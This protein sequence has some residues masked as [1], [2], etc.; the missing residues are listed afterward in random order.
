[1]LKHPKL[2]LQRIERFLDSELR[3]RVYQDAAPL[4]VAVCQCAEPIAHAEALR[5]TYRPVAPGFRWG[6]VWSTAWFR[7]RGRM[8]DFFA[9][10][11]VVARINTSS[12]A[13]VWEGDSPSQGLD[14]NRSEYFLSRSAVA[15]EPVELFVEA[16]GNHLFGISAMGRTDGLAGAAEPFELKEACLARFDRRHWDLYHDF[17]VLLGVLKA[18]PE[19]EPRR[20]QLLY[21]L[22]ECANCYVM[23]C[24]PEAAREALAPALALPASASSH[25]VSAL[26]HSHID[27][28]W[29]WPLRETVRKC[30]RTFATALRTMERY[31]E[32]RF[33]QSQ[34]QLYAFTKEHFPKLYERI[35]RAVADGRWEPVGAM[36]VE[37][38]CNIPSGE[39][40][41]RQIL[42]GKRFFMEEFGVESDIAWLPDA[43]GYS[44][45]LP[46][47]LKKARVDYFVTQKL[48]WSQF[49]RFPHHAFWWEGID[50][51]RILSHFLP[52]DTYNG[53]FTPEQLRHGERAFRE[54]D[55]AASWLYLFGY[56]DGGGGPTPE[57]LETAQRVKS[58]DGL[59]RV[60][61]EPARDFFRRAAAEAK[62]LPLWVGEL[63]LE[64][65]R[66]T[67]TTQ[68]H[69]KLM[70]RR[71]ELLLRD[72][73]F[74][75]SIRP[76]GLKSYPAA[77]L[78]RCWKLVLLNQF[79]DVLPGSSIGRVYADSRQQYAE[80][81]ETGE[82]LVARSLGELT[83]R[84]DTS[85][86]Q[87]PVVAWN[88]LS[89]A[90]FGAVSLPI[91]DVA[92]QSV[93]DPDGFGQPVQV[94]VEDGER[95]ALFV[96]EAPAH[97]YA[98]YDL[99]AEA[100][101]EVPLTE[102]SVSERCLEN[103]LI[104]IELD[105]NG[106][107][108][109]IYDKR[110]GREVLLPGRKGNV[111]Q[112]FDDHP[113][114]SDAWDVDPFY[115][116]TGR[117]L[118]EAESVR[119]LETGPVR[120]ALEVVR[121]FGSSTI[122]Q[123]IRLVAHSPRIDFATEV[124]WR[125]SHKLL[126][127]AFP[128]DIHAGRASFEIQYGHVERPTHANTS[129]D[130][131]RFEVVAHKWIDISEGSYGVALLNDGKYGHDVQGSTLRVS[132]LRAPKNPDPNADMGP[133]RFTYALYPH[134]GG[135]RFGD[136]V[137]E[138][139]RFNVPLRVVPT[140]PH[141]GELPTE[142]SFL[143]VDSGDV[144]IEA[145]KRAEKEDALV[146]RL[147]EAHNT[148]GPVRLITT[149]P[150]KDA[151]LADL[152][153]DPIRPVPVKDGEIRLEVKPFEIVTLLLR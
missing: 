112:L 49:N 141:A 72:A 55:R 51:T 28:A 119:V 43:F 5:R 149:L 16:A 50:G 59:P 91:G 62:D 15:G 2:T 103:G 35:K 88:S 57:M 123:Q 93:I 25:R 90:H 142:Y 82:D 14:A 113:L 1:M 68:A 69:N 146:V 4:D 124:D 40:L 30:S 150:V 92:P 102:V 17:R 126:K 111:L 143:S 98:V 115:A 3:P 46:Q 9:G 11:E 6:P 27:V 134:R 19:D 54:S 18:L 87:R 22:N 136:V 127:A 8:P 48:S 10:E 58:L 78:E 151:F 65:H 86:A 104:C 37:A 132:L 101:G 121:R 140:H 152:M 26:G 144:F 100:P 23:G 106:L 13:L 120:G 131:A 20:A 80:V 67:Y 96:A 108:A 33:A 81:M 39:S 12:E 105:D 135:V 60:E 42:H 73:E 29:L 153:E 77:A 74:Y 133:H 75:A 116:E 147:Y 56:G 125:E 128:V 66:G 52:A 45:A 118:V 79:H 70:N 139:D 31:P 85:G 84:I 53:D 71:C 83:E 44:A 41:V 109:S 64:L 47:I 94:V 95:R 76:D 7:L 38:D 148:R 114:A 61:Q 110:R 145:V 137:T 129:W 99:S 130:M 34:P 122:R 63:Y 117:D 21:A 24:G 89:R 138:A 36:W 97:G 107:I 32:F